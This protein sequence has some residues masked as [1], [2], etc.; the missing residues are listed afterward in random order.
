MNPNPAF[1]ELPRYLLGVLFILG[2][3]FLSL[4]ILRPFLPALIWATVIVVATWPLMKKVEAAL[5]G[6]RGPAVAIMTAA[7]LLTVLLPLAYAGLAIADH[8]DAAVAWLKRLASTGLPAAPPWLEKVPLAGPR[9]HGQWQDIAAMTPAEIQARLAP[10]ALGTAGWILQQ[11]GGLA[12]FMLHLLLTAVLAA[13]LY[14]TGETA[15]AGVRAFATRLG[16]LHG[17]HSVTLAGQA[18]RGV[19]F[20]V[21]VTAIVQ[22]ALGGIGLAVAG[23]PFAVALTALMFVLAVAQ[24]GPALVLAGVVAWLFWKGEDLTAWIFLPFAIFVSVLDNF[25]RPFLIKFGADLPLVLIFAGVIGGL[26]AFGIVGLFIGPVILAITYTE[27]VAWVTDAKSDLE[28][29]PPAA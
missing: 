17:D 14:A 12:A 8:A 13:L 26:L 9:L 16:G 27:L 29:P 11:A 20:G 7:I 6:R 19:A 1:R 28:A 15:T 24:V 22:S 5:W 2:I 3:L 10:Y 25:L 4:W 23:I 18:I 21:V